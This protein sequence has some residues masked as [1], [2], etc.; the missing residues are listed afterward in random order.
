MS[1]E[2][3]SACRRSQ[4]VMTCVNMRLSRQRFWPM[5]TQR[6]RYAWPARSTNSSMSIANWRRGG[7]GIRALRGGDSVQLI[8]SMTGEDGSTSVFTSTRGRETEAL[9]TSGWKSKVARYER[10]YVSGGGERA[11]KCHRKDWY[12]RGSWGRAGKRVASAQSVAI[13]CSFSNASLKSSSTTG[14]GGTV[15]A[16]RRCIFGLKAPGTVFP[17]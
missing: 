6:S 10:A 8:G 4:P 11:E 5:A 7:L 15:D 17:S 9:R 2:L 14:R 1:I 16:R 13:W 3:A 12:S